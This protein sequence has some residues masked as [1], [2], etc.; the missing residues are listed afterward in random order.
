[1]KSLPLKLTIFIILLFA[2]VITTCLLWT[3]VR[4]RYYTAK[5]KS[6]NLKER[7]AG[8][9]FLLANGKEGI[10]ALAKNLHGGQDAA[11]LIAFCWNDINMDLLGEFPPSE[12]GWYAGKAWHLWHPIHE[13]SARGLIDTAS[14]LVDK[15]ARLDIDGSRNPYDHGKYW[16]SGK[17]LHIAAKTGNTRMVLLLINKGADVN[18]PDR[19]GNWTALHIAAQFGHYNVAKLLIKNGAALDAE[20]FHGKTSIEYMGDHPPST[21]LAEAVKCWDYKER[22]PDYCRNYIEDGEQHIRVAKLLLENGAS[23][24][25][26]DTH[27]QSILQQAIYADCPLVV[28]RFLV[29]SGAD[30]FIRDKKYGLTAMDIALN[31]RIKENHNEIVSLLRAHGGKTGE[32]LKKEAGE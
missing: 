14:L 30:I 26:T 17:P 32:E 25:H 13:A 15:G 31:K 12:R 20:Y 3:P 16:P 18:A 4:I 2:L 24:N 27:G 11:K 22:A 10:D 23:I 28:I 5:L 8:I 6:D 29:D 1:M 19:T 7:V 21:P 9:D